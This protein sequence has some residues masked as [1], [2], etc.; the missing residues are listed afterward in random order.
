MSEERP[1]KK[2]LILPLGMWWFAAVM[3]VV[4]SVRSERTVVVVTEGSMIGVRRDSI[5]SV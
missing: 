3:K 4:R 2:L 1:G 5:S